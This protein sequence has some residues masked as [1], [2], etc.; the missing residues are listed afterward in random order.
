MSDEYSPEELRSVAEA[1]SDEALVAE[2]RRPTI[3]AGA[4]EILATEALARLLE[5]A[6]ERRKA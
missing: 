4:R 1:C 3:S 2:L 6:A 5:D